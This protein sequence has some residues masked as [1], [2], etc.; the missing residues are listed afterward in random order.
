VSLKST[1]IRLA[2]KISRLY[3]QRIF[4]AKIHRAMALHWR[5]EVRSDGL[6]LTAART[7]LQIEWLARDLHPW[8]RDLP[9]ARAQREFSAQCFDDTDAA[10]TRLFNEIPVLDAIQVCIRR[11]AADA[12]LLTG[13]VEREDFER[14]DPSP[15]AMKLRRFGLKFRMN[16]EGLDLSGID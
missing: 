5:G 12:P 6:R 4:F 9:R 2:S 10:L 8:D 11:E 13:T 16:N 15:A 1:V 3:S 7:V 14:N